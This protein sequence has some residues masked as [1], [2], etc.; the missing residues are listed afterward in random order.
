MSKKS[1]CCGCSACV[2][3]CESKAISLKADEQGFD[4]PVIDKKSCTS[5]GRCASVCA[6]RFREREEKLQ[7]EQPAV[8]IINLQFTDNY[9]A[10]I[11]ASML[12]RAVRETVD[13]NIR[14]ETLYYSHPTPPRNILA[15]HLDKMKDGEMTLLQYIKSRLIPQPNNKSLVEIER[16]RHQKFQLFRDSFLTLTE[17]RNNQALDSCEQNYIALIAGSDVIWQPKRILSVRSKAFLLDFGQDSTR[18]IAYAPSIDS[19]DKKLLKKCKKIFK[20]HLKSFDFLSVRE[21]QG[22]AFLQPLT[23]KEIKLCCDPALLYGAAAYSE[24]IEKSSVKC[25]E[26]F[27]YAYVLGDN[28]EAVK[29]AERLAREKGLKLC[30]Y[31]PK[32][33]CS[34]DYIDCICDGPSEFLYRL[35]NAKYVVT[36]SFHCVVFSV[37]FCRPFLAFVRGASSIKIPS[38]LKELEISDRIAVGS[39]EADIDAAQIDFE[40]ANA[41]LKEMGADSWSYIRNALSGL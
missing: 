23:D 15:F 22:R 17:R 14:V 4:Y 13:K 32:I 30:L 24:M 5:C 1:K 19:S 9:G 3:I 6:F 2:C 31:A 12:E 34:S 25:E 11:A 26:G 29:Y 10:V 18:R 16:R 35:K 20:E 41:R 28:I 7:R 33:K 40:R 36:T 8:G 21:E 39:D 27:V 37:M 38:L